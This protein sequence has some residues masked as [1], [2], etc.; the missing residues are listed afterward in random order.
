M[1]AGVFSNGNEVQMTSQDTGGASFDIGGTTFTSAEVGQLQSTTSFEDI[2]PYAGVGYDFEV[3]GKVGLNLDIGLLW[4]GEG[5]VQIQADGL[6]ADQPAFQMA[7]ETERLEIENE[8]S[9]YKAWPVLSLG[10][11][12]NF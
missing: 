11:I 9:D 4:Q 7:L 10:F 3:F 12:Y 5:S 1:T 8:V 2:A 6:A